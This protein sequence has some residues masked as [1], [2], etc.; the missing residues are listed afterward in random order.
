MI[1]VLEVRGIDKVFKQG[2]T[3]FEALKNVDLTVH[4]GEFVIIMGPSGSGKS[5]FLHVLG[6][7]EMPSG[8]QMIVD[9]DVMHNLYKEPFATHYRRKKIGFVFQFFNLLSSLNA[10][11]NVALPLILEGTSERNA[12]K[13]AAN[14]LRIVGL[15]DKSEH[16]PSE[17]SG[18]QQQRVALARA[19]IHRPQ[20]L[21]ADEPTGSLDSK[22][23]AEILELLRDMKM[24][25]KQ[26][27]VMVTHDPMVATYGDRIVFFKDGRI[28]SELANNRHDEDRSG[29]SMAIMEHLHKISAGDVA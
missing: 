8:G 13:E 11:E 16:L 20:I 15:H 19:M 14:M 9:G 27:I 12:N 18:G 3:T 6:G 29:R 26:S 17:L 1:P 5:T 22:T 10:L 4:R 28:V 25:M 21:L 24:R 2:E 23:S 7:L